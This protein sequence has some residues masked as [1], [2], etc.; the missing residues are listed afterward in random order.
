MNWESRSPRNLFGWKGDRRK[1]LTALRM[2]PELKL[3]N[4][5]PQIMVYNGGARGPWYIVAE[6][7]P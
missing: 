7:K 2:L 1:A 6:R 3:G 5:A 4:L